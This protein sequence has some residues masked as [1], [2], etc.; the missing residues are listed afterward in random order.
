[1]LNFG[2]SGTQ[3]IKNPIPHS[4]PLT[5]P[6]RPA[7]PLP[8]PNTRSFQETSFSP[9]LSVNEALSKRPHRFRDTM[10]GIDKDTYLFWSTYHLFDFTIRMM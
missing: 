7:P 5:L 3:S 1:M 9:S 4:R 10:F 6:P 2:V 8:T